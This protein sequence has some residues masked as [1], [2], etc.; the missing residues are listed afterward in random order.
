MFRSVTVSFRALIP[1]FHL[2][3]VFYWVGS[4]HAVSFRT[5]FSPGGPLDWRD[6]LSGHSGVAVTMGNSVQTDTPSDAEISSVEGSDW[7]VI[8]D[9]PAEPL[10]PAQFALAPRQPPNLDVSLENLGNPLISPTV[11]R[12]GMINSLPMV[13]Q[14][15]CKPAEP[16]RSMTDMR[17]RSLMFDPTTL[18]SNRPNPLN[19]DHQPPLPGEKRAKTDHSGT[20]QTSASSLIRTKT[21]S[22]IPFLVEL[23]TNILTALGTLSRVFADIGTHANFHQMASVILDAFA[24]STLHRYLFVLHF[25]VFCHGAMSRVWNWPRS[26]LPQFWMF[27][28]GAPEILAWKALRCWKHYNGVGN[29]LTFLHGYFWTH[30]WFRA[31]RN[32]RFQ[33]TAMSLC[34]FHFTWWPNGNGA[35]CK[36]MYLNMKSWSLVDS[37]WWSGQGFV[38]QTSS[39]SQ[40]VQ[41]FVPKLKYAASAG[42]PRP[43]LRV[44]RGE[45]VQQ[46]FYLLVQQH[47]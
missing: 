29:R 9:V 35:C 40:W 8:S 15:K 20:G 3:P 45:L 18:A 14:S 2:Q 30:L 17:P 25:K 12:P 1:I 16:P 33:Q 43:A 38:T 31:G 36:Q 7:H 24:A 37:F 21:P 6:G 32:Q 22:S 19:Y 44:N 26:Q 42:V 39:A 34:L 11:S 23:W 4:C 41:W 46:D 5:G 47:G 27:Y 13:S 10:L 28:K